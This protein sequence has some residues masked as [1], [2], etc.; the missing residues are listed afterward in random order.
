MILQLVTLVILCIRRYLNP[1]LLIYE[2]VLLVE[3]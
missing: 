2:K 3:A 1:Y